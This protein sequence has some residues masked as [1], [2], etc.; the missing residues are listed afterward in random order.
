MWKTLGMN[1]ERFEKMRVMPVDVY[2]KMYLSQKNRP[3][4]MATS[5]A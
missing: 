5:T 3:A 1:V 2:S 4:R